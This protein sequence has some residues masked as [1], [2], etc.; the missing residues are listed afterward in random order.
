M[1]IIKSYCNIL[2]EGVWLNGKVYFESSHKQFNMDD[3]FA[4]IYDRMQIDYRKFYKMDAMSKLGFLAAELLLK[5]ADREY[6]K[7]DM[8]IILFNSSSSLQADMNYQKT[9]QD[10]DNF[11]PSPAEFVHTLPNIVA[12]E[13]AIRNKIYGETVFYVMSGFYVDTISEMIDYT[14]YYA[15]L[16]CSLAGWLEIDIFNHKLHCSMMLCSTRLSYLPEGLEH[17][18]AGEALHLNNIKLNDI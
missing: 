12:G 18:Y 16:K 4:A 2:P 3:F 10:K 6:P 14:M 1:S 7:Q 13:I 8:G 5:G 17:I 15:G 9:I 11:F